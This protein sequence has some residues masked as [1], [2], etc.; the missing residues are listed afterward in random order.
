M[1]SGLLFAASLGCLYFAASGYQIA[2]IQEQLI[3]QVQKQAAVQDLVNDPRFKK[4]L[5]GD[6]AATKLILASATSL[7]DEQNSEGQVSAFSDFEKRKVSVANNSATA[8]MFDHI[9]NDY[10]I[11]QKTKQDLT[12]AQSALNG[13]AAEIEQV[14]ASYKLLVEDVET[15]FQTKPHAADAPAASNQDDA[16]GESPFNVYQSGLLAGIPR[17]A[18]ISDN[19]TDQDGIVSLLRQPVD[20]TEPPSVKVERFRSEMAGLSA[21]YDE[22]SARQD[23]LTDQIEALDT[24]TDSLRSDLRTDLF[25]LLSAAHRTQLDNSAL[26]VYQELS[27]RFPV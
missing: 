14:T 23:K 6:D 7:E 26:K 2:V 13:T 11:W 22:I 17:V 27:R 3:S 4:F 18:G 16:G 5:T 15:V 1:V 25:L 24:L 8:E 20:Q 10:R 9:V 21:K 12:A 19:I